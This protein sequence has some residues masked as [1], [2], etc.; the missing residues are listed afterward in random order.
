MTYRNGR[1]VVALMAGTAA[2]A[3]A[4]PVNAQDTAAG[5]ADAEGDA[6]IIVSARRRDERITDVPIA[7]TAISGDQP[8]L[9]ARSISPTCRTR[10]R[11]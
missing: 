7:V 6:E 1:F 3:F 9:W 10:R 11:T 2:L 8:R 5:V 4:M